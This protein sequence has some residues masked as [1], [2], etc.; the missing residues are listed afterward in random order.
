MDI[1]KAQIFLK[2]LFN[3][4]FVNEHLYDLVLDFRKIWLSRPLNALPD[5]FSGAQKAVRGE[6]ADNHQ[7]NATR[8]I[9]W[10]EEIGRCADHIVPGKSTLEHAGD[11]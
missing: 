1:Y 8:E 2:K 10:L 6:I 3:A 11:G 4:K 9:S 5:T 7:P